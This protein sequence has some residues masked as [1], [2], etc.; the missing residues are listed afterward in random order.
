[1]R[2]REGR[3]ILITP[4]EDPGFDASA[5]RHP[6]S[7]PLSPLS[8][9]ADQSPS[10]VDSQIVESFP[11]KR[12]LSPSIFGTASIVENNVA[13]SISS[14]IDVT[15]VPSSKDPAPD[16][17]ANKQ[18]AVH[19][20]P[21]NIRSCCNSKRK[22]HLRLAVFV[23]NPHGVWIE[24]EDITSC[25]DKFDN[26]LTKLAEV[27]IVPREDV[28]GVSFSF[29]DVAAQENVYVYPGHGECYAHFGQTLEAL[30]KTQRHTGVLRT[31][32]DLGIDDESDG[33][34]DNNPSLT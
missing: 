15:H 19:Q 33:E 6:D 2:R 34:L 1:M 23:R 20:H 8:S 5:P 30:A 22:H 9:P 27:A 31:Y 3:Q 14:D 10:R 4:N 28:K 16:K 18:P 7:L 17:V 25:S 24:L 29:P 32:V 21:Q 12:K 11:K 13:T 26:L